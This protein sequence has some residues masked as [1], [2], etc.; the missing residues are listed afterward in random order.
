MNTKQLSTLLPYVLPKE[1]ERSITG[2]AL[3]SRQVQAG[4]LF[5][6]LA[7]SHTHGEKYIHSAI[8]RGA[9]A[10]FKEGTQETQEF[11]AD[12][13]PCI[14]I[15]HLSQELGNIAAR[16]YDYPSRN[17]SVIGVTGTN[18]KTSVTHF[19]AQ[20]LQ[21]K[22][23]CGLFGTLGYGIYGKLVPGKHTTPDAIRLQQLFAELLTQHVHH[24]V[25]EVSSHALAQGRVNGIEFD[26]A[27]FTNLTRDHLDYHCTMAAYGQAKQKLFA[28]PTLKTV[29][30]NYDDPFSR[31]ILTILPSFVKPLTY[32]I[33][34]D[35]ADVFISD[36]HYTANGYQF[37]VYSPWGNME[38]RSSLMGR[39]NLSNML[40]AFTVLLQKGLTLFQ[41]AI[42]LEKISP[43]PG[44]MERFGQNPTVIVDYAH[45]PD[46]LR[47]ALSALRPHCR[48][49]LWCVF[50]CGGDRD[51][52]KRPI[53]GATAQQGADK[54]V[55]TDDNPRHEKSQDIIEAILAGCSRPQE[56]TVITNREQ[57][58]EYAIKN[59][60]N[61]DIV[62]IAGKGHEDYQQVGDERLAFNDR[63]LAKQFTASK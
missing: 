16:F 63:T 55:I 43:I 34:S 40:A 51:P 20:A 3:D 13:I 58:I 9:V 56:V 4:N 49:K 32:S 24:V 10:I 15:N 52:G 6:A 61:Q 41:A 38:L 48:G 45:T 60:E 8:E 57:A 29:V 28:W 30:I 54:V 44:R 47:H 17:L 31:E 23:P 26:T 39:F 35:Q 59:A 2:L 19:I 46:A 33:T 18:G 11:L 14:T 7:G 53:M 36:W 1:Y 22:R 5:F 12:G 21:Q 50:G 27:V 42:Q 37:V 62:L 25:M